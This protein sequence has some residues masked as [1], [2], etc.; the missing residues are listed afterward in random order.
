MARALNLVHAGAPW[1]LEAGLVF[2][3]ALLPLVYF[4][5]GR[6]NSSAE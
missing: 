1:Q 4:L 5:I 2:L 3:A 6:R